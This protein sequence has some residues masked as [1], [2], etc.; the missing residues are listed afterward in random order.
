MHFGDVEQHAIGNME[1]CVLLPS[2]PSSGNDLSLVDCVRVYFLTG[3]I[4]KIIII[5]KEVE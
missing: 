2:S 1:Y 5:I 3:E 4:F